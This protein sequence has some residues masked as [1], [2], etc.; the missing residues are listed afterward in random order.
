VATDLAAVLGDSRG[1]VAAQDLLIRPVPFCRA[2]GADHEPADTTC[3][4]CD[5]DTRPLP[6]AL[7]GEIG[8]LYAIRRGLRKRTAIRVGDDGDAVAL[9]FEHGEA[10]TVEAGAL[11]EPAASPVPEDVPAARCPQGRLLRLAAA[12]RDCAFK[13]K[14]D[15]GALV[16]AAI[17][18]VRDETTAR[19]VAQDAVAFG[20]SEAI[21]RLPLTST[22]RAWVHAV[23]AAHER[24]A[25]ALIAAATKLPP[26]GYRPKLTLVASIARAALEQGLDVDP[27]GPHL[28]AYSAEEPLAEVLRRAFGFAAVPAA[29]A[30]GRIASAAERS[31]TLTRT[32]GF[33]PSL[34]AEL[35]ATLGVL[36]GNGGSSTAGPLRLLPVHGRLVVALAAPRRGLISSDDIPHVA[37]PLLD[38]LIDA[39]AISPDDALGNLRDPE[40]A[41]YLLARLSPERLTDEDVEALDHTDERLRRAFRRGDAAVLEAAGDTP[42]ARRLRALDAVRSGRG[43]LPVLDDLDGEAHAVAADLLALKEAKAAGRSVS[44]ALTD[45]LVV[46]PSVWPVL[47]EIA[48][49]TTLEPTPALR[50]RLPAFTEWLSL[51]QAREH[52]YLGQWQA[53][54]EASDRCL[55]L[56]QDEAVCDEALN[57]KACGL[58]HLGDDRGAI[59]ALEKAIEGA[60]SEALLANIGVVAVGLDP[61][62]AARHLGALINEA[63]TIAM[64]VAAARRAVM[65]W[66]ES[67]SASWRNSDNSPLP[68]AF[69]DALRELVVGPLD[70]GDFRDFVALLATHDS[71]WIANEHS[72]ARSP[73]RET[74]EARFYVAR[75]SSLTRMIQIMGDAMRSG[76]A[77]QWVLD[78]RNSLR[79]AAV[80]ILFDNLDEPD[81]TFGTVALEMADQHVLA[82]DY[83]HLLLSLLGI[84]GVAYHLSSRHEEVGDHF[85]QRM[86]N[87]RREWQQLDGEQ[88]QLLEPLAELATRRV[89]LNRMDARDR[90][91]SAAIEMY[92][93]AIDL[94]SDSYPGSPMYAEA[95]RRIATAARV[96]A[97]ARDDLRPLI[98]LV[99]HAGA[100]DDMNK[101]MDVSRELEQRCL[102][103]LN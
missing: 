66:S 70:L 27:L 67:D 64:R 88:R 90:E 45:R 38:D 31:L 78:E 9:L 101:T 22:E 62:T 96:A 92:N 53:A 49:P 48:G 36:I 25:V 74:L 2:C 39:G 35:D 61:E 8:S 18:S 1:S 76:A 68:D 91:L 97:A 77:P 103:V 73:H 15:P 4:Q 32:Q 3:G 11:P 102:N 80:D 50:G 82:N 79:D 95:L 58:H 7:D 5:R 46:D 59:A 55:E 33:P 63:P 83:D 28:E 23:R 29:S 12:A 43:G 26:S 75:A 24:D 37:P 65:I 69:Q 44:D 42:T 17:E 89:A 30:N 21:E 52:L 86:L 71:D 57:L 10:A 51:H 6:S 54:V 60:H 19:L 14:W 99:D 72:L 84:A 56:A 93:G 47:V 41:R 85:V 100:R 81:A 20:Y 34:R 40:G 98:P 94:G 16:D 13:S 87:V